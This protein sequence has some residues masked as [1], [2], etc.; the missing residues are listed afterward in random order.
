MTVSLYPRPAIRRSCLG[1]ILLGLWLALP[2][3]AEVSETAVYRL[4]FQA[5]WSAATHPQV[6]QPGWLGIKHQGGQHALQVGQQ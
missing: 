4:R 3:A 1:A 2:A 5:D 6:K